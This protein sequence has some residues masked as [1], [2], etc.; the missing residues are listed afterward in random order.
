MN[1]GDAN[2]GIVGFTHRISIPEWVFIGSERNH[3]G[4]K[5]RFSSVHFGKR[6]AL[7]GPLVF[8]SSGGWDDLR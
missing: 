5:R 2:R 3:N 1:G 4:K 7:A 8:L 6:R